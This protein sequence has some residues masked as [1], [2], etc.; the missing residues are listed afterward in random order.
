VKTVKQG[1]EGRGSFICVVWLG[2]SKCDTANI[3]REMHHIKN[4]FKNHAYSTTEIQLPST[5][6]K[7]RSFGIQ[8]YWHSYHIIQ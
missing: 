2:Q 7:S 1:K 8:T 3:V 5:K 4:M 6:E